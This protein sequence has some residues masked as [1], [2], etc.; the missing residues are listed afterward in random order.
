MAYA[1]SYSLCIRLINLFLSYT[2]ELPFQEAF[3]SIIS[4][5]AFICQIKECKVCRLEQYRHSLARANLRG[6]FRLQI[7]ESWSLWNR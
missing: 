4:L 3:L 1:L 5:R 2:L 7:L 6:L